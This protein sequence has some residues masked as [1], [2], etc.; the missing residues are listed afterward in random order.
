MPRRTR[1]G[2]IGSNWVDDRTKQLPLSRETGRHRREK[3]GCGIKAL[4]IVL[5]VIAGIV[6]C[7]LGLALGLR[8]IGE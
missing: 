3:E 4:L 5:I 1:H 2:Y 6:V 7:A 8:M